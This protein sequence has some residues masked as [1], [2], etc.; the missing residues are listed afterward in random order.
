ML[1]QCCFLEIK[2][3]ILNDIAAEYVTYWEPE[4][5]ILAEMKKI[6]RRLLE[7]LHKFK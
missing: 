2:T 1:L 5:K 4:E 7:S 6:E 3:E